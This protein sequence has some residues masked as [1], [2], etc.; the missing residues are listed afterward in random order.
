LE[1][2]ALILLDQQKDREAQIA[3]Q[4][5]IDAGSK[6]ARAWLELGRLKSDS[7]QLKK[8][9]ELNPRW[10]E[11]Y[12]QL[13]DLNPAIDKE[14]L[15]QRATLLKKAAALDPRSIDYWQALAKTDIAAKDFAEAQK[16][17]AGA[18]HAAAT[19]EERE[20]IHQVRSQ[21]EENRF[22]YEA[23]ERK[24][25]KD[26]READI[27]RVKNQS[28]AAIHA[29]EVAARK[30]MNPNGTAPPKAE[31]W[32]EA[33]DAGPSVQGTFQRLDCLGQG[34]RLVIQT[35]DGKTVQLLMSDPSQITTG[36]GGDQT[37]VCGPQKN[38]R[39]VVVRYNAKPDAKLHT[40]GIA[41][42]IEFH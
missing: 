14:H 33:A 37:L 1:G 35:A 20:R 17:W 42:A 4:D 38:A 36:G 40:V 3:L 39:Q 8:A 41:T 26:E 22:D 18:E 30:K 23:A 24:R 5:A 2:L 25:I 10:G 12:Y 9:S 34:A 13:A 6:S 11:P 32:Y 15:E 29:A 19:D 21:L 7:D 16:A 27:Q 28:E 31:A